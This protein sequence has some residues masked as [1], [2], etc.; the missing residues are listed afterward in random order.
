MNSNA[1][2]V[3]PPVFIPKP[4]T[5]QERYAAS[6]ESFNERIQ[7]EL[8]PEVIQAPLTRKNYKKKFHNLI[9]WEEKRHIEILDEK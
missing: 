9:C 5:A 8:H 4:K 2:F 1:I 3:Q 6:K 7:E